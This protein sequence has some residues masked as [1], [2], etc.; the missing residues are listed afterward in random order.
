MNDYLILAEKPSA[1]KKIATAFGGKKGMYGGHTYE[2]VSSHGHLMTLKEPDQMV[3][4]DKS[5]KYKSWNLTD[6]PWNSSDF[7]WEK[8]YIREYNS[9]TKKYE[10]T[11]G[12]IDSIKM[13]SK[14]AKT[15]VI[16]TDNDPSGE[17]QL[18]A[19]EII[20]AIGW[21]ESVLRMYF[22][23]E[24][25]KSLQKAFSSLVDVSDPLKD[26]NFLKAD[27]RNRWDFLSMQL[28][29]ISTTVAREAGYNV[30]SIR[31]G[32]LKSVIVRHIYEQTLAIKNYVKKPY[33]EVKYKDDQGN[34]FSR[35]LSDENINNERYDSKTLATTDMDGYKESNVTQISREVKHQVP[36]RLLDLAGIASTL[37]PKGFSADEVL[38]TYQKMYEAEILSYPRTE[39]KKITIEQFNDLLPFVDK[40]ANVVGI[41]TSLLT[42]RS[43][44]KT[45]VTTNAAH[46]A[47]RPGLKVPNSLDDLLSYGK[48]GPEIYKLLANNY[49][50]IIAEDY[51]YEA[52]KARITDYPNFIATINVPIKLNYKA[53]FID[54]D[55]ESE[56]SA[57]GFGKTAAPYIY[58]GANKKPSKPTMKWLMK[59]LEKNNVGQG[60]TRTSTL[61]D[62]SNKSDKNAMLIEK[63][64]VYTLTNVG[65]I[66]AILNANTWIG[67]VDIT[68]KLID[69]MDSVGEF[70]MTP[71]KVLLSADNTIKH[72]MPIIM[73]NGK[74]LL[75]KIGTP[76]G[77]LRVPEKKEKIQGLFKGEE[78]SFN[79]TWG[80]HRFTDGE[81]K[82]LLEGK[83]IVFKYRNKEISGQLEKQSYKGHQF[84][85]FKAN[86]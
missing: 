50:A 58:E 13:A 17:G 65:E 23:D 35:K 33:Y 16:A 3:P 49:L 59:F 25:V 9:R 15:I 68:K 56:Y 84:V 80:D 42:H 75:T 2:I 66:S 38:S 47:N 22:E 39:D 53:V 36:G 63:K 27:A 43:A 30:K 34:I 11:K 51:E 14:S 8:T 60:A 74:R 19:W 64:G 21:K 26:G 37:A 71:Q 79:A 20:Q 10:S 5:D 83:L 7:K 73:D 18:L 82:T 54:D 44:R 28:T 76:S 45:H 1:A 4:Q 85:G 70:K 32:R 61:A 77:D 62:I 52:I 6:L 41:D 72:D 55:S 48:I 81:T 69:G 40:I 67:S 78:I 57:K 86:K 46:G 31:Q 29:R 12:T 24:S